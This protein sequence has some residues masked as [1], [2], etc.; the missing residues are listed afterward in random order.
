MSTE[1]HPSAT[2]HPGARLG[3]G[4][5]IGQG[6]IVGEHVVIGDRSQVGAYAILD[7]W[8]TLG[9]D[10]RVFSHAVL[11]TECQDLKYRGERSYLKIGNRN[12]IREF[13]TMNR[14]TG[15]EQATVVGDGNLF[16]AYCH[17]AHNCRIGNHNVLANAIAMAG[18]VEVMDH[19]TVGGLVALHQF[20]RIGSY[21]MIGGHSRVP[22][23]VPP[24]IMCAGSPLRIAGIN[25]IGLERKGFTPEQ[26]DRL[27]KAYRVLYR[28]K[29][30]ISQALKKLEEEHTS[31]E[32]RPLIEFIRTSERGIAK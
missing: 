17:V 27:E 16:M 6:A 13:V 3:D 31:E 32:V 22:K 28:S 18:H 8:T 19:A 15:E 10:N 24:F 2:V 4:V 1:I 12:T 11:G 9:S 21:V 20:I 25:R 26:M 5:K 23:D 7:G 29:L 30:N 14:A